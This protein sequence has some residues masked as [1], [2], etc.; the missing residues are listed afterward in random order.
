MR[1]ILAGLLAGA[2]VC[3]LRGLR[4]A[5]LLG[6]VRSR[7]GRGICPIVESGEPCVLIDGHNGPHRGSS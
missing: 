7:S 5:L 2:L 4:A 1:L 3:L 6:A